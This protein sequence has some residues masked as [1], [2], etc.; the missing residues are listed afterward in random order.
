MTVYVFF[1]FASLLCHFPQV[2][3]LR[4][5]I[6]TSSGMYI[7]T[8]AVEEVFKNMIYIRDLE[9][10]WLPPIRARPAGSFPPLVETYIKDKYNHQIKLIM[11]WYCIILC[12]QDIQK[13]KS[14]ARR[15][16]RNS[17]C[18]VQ[19]LWTFVQQQSK[20]KRRDRKRRRYKNK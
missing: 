1:R 6:D 10:L 20:N 14:T 12:E 11:P 4:I 3:D 8:E 5:S 17:A 13:L 19:P 15:I 9:F 16:Y 2:R 7:Q 18:F